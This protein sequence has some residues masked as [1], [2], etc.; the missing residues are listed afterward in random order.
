MTLQARRPDESAIATAV[1]FGC[2]PV[3]TGFDM[4]VYSADFP[5]ALR[6]LVRQATGGECVFLQGAGGNVLPR[7]AFTTDEREAVRVGRRLAL[8]ALRSVADRRAFPVRA[9][10]Y[11]EGS[12]TPIAKYRAEPVDAPAPVL[13]A[14][15]ET[16]RFPLLPH[17][18]VEEVDA[19]LAD[20]EAA[21]ARAVEAGDPGQVK[22]A[23][24]GVGW[25]RHVRAML[26]D[27]S[28]PTEVP[29]PVHALRIGDGAIVTGPGEVFTEIGMAV[30]ERGPGRPTRIPRV[31]QRPPVVLPDRGRVR[32]RRLRG[33]DVASRRQAAE[34]RGAGLRQ[35]AGGARRPARGGPLPR[36]A[37]VA[38]GRG[39]DGDGRA[40]VAARR[41]A[42]APRS[43]EQWRLR[44]GSRASG[45]TRR[46][47]GQRP[48]P[49]CS[50]PLGALEQ[51][52]PHL[53]VGTDALLAE[54]VCV[55]AA[56]AATRD[57]LVAP[58]LWSGFS[59]HHM[60]FGAT[61]TL[62]P[63][64]LLAL[65][66]DVVESIATWCDSRAGRQRP[67]RQPRAAD[68]AR[69]GGPGARASATGS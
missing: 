18:T 33:G 7:V 21:Y 11:D 24:Y 5:G 59:P 54:E 46:P 8:E 48:A 16:V 42:R 19:W 60:G 57:V 43:G 13:A 66:R 17:P 39:L 37:T 20:F 53:P 27:G 30:K 50:L 62:R 63:E 68:D 56:A 51:H 38:R 65:L 36:R 29:G 55:R 47:P 1:A 35:P 15:S 34:P 67:R 41:G 10:R 52:G 31:Y 2:H 14:A 23:W 9:Q 28:A 22:V 49:R 58:A 25:A 69:P 40:A 12:V 45:A 44:P 4:D 61:V 26:L 64:T 32:A 3:T 6:D